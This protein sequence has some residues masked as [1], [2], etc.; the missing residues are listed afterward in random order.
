MITAHPSAAPALPPL[1][2][3]LEPLLPVLATLTVTQLLDFS[4]PSSYAALSVTQL[5]HFS[6]PYSYP[7]L[8]AQQ[9]LQRATQQHPPAFKS[10]TPELS[11]RNFLRIC[12]LI[13]VV[14]TLHLLPTSLSNHPLPKHHAGHRDCQVQPVDGALPELAPQHHQAEGDVG[15]EDESEEP[16]AEEEDRL[17]ELPGGVL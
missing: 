10:V 1:L 4:N 3:A 9:P 16:V 11:H 5:L 13:V 2:P 12:I 17:Q 14:H 15:G 7:T 8:T 6:N